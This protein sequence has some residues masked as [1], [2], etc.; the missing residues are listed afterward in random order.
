M[1]KSVADGLDVT[2][3]ARW[4]SDMPACLLACSWYLIFQPAYL[5]CTL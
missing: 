2:Y 1:I 3:K 4:P 5:G